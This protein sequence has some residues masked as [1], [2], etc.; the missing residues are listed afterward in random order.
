MTIEMK[1]L[2]F[3]L[4]GFIVSFGVSTVSQPGSGGFAAPLAGQGSTGGGGG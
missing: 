3:T 1:L 2:K 4:N